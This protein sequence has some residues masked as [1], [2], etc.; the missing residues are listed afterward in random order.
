[1]LFNDFEKKLKLNK[2]YRIYVVLKIYKDLKFILSWYLF[3]GGEG[4][5]LMNF[6]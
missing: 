3:F 4:V 6:M 1:M 5:D 2:D